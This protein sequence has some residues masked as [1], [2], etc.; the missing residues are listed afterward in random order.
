ML[1]QAGLS[2]VVIMIIL[3]LILRPL[4]KEIFKDRNDKK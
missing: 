1:Q 3:A 2:I 4:F